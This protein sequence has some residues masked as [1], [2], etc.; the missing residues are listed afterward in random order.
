MPAARF[1]FNTIRAVSSL[2]AAAC[3]VSRSTG[4]CVVAFDLFETLSLLVEG[5]GGLWPAYCL[6][7]LRS[8]AA[9]FRAAGKTGVTL[10]GLRLSRASLIGSFRLI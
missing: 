4:W 6:P 2:I 3:S 5:G 9:R 10:P 7:D 1:G 8:G